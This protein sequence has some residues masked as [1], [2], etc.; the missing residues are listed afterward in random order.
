MKLCVAIK[1]KCRDTK[2]VK[3]NLFES[4]LGI[5]ILAKKIMEIYREKKKD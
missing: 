5:S 2:R 4:N 1:H 3:K